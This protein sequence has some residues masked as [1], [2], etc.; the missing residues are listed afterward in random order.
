MASELDTALS[1]VMDRLTAPGGPLE[2]TTFQR[3]G[4]DLP[5]LKFAPPSLAHYFDMFCAQHGEAEFLVDGDPTGREQLA[6]GGVLVGEGG[7]QVAH[8][9]ARGQLERGAVAAQALAQAGE[10]EDTDVHGRGPLRSPGPR[11]IRDG[12]TRSGGAS[13]KFRGRSRGTISYPCSST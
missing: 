2:T 11:Q 6:Q 7:E 3:F 9:G 13:P 12:G 8:G 4:R 5:M 10:Q 1:S